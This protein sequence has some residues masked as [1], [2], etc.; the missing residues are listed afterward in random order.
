[1]SACSR[2]GHKVIPLD[3]FN[4]NE[5]ITS[6]S[7]EQMLLNLARLRYREVPMFLAVSSVLTQ[8]S[9]VGTLGAGVSFGKPVAGAADEIINT[10][11]RL[12]YAERPTITY[13]P[14]VGQELSQQLFTPI[15][16]A[17]L[18]SLAQSGWPTEQLLM[19]SLKRLN[20]V[21]NLPFSTIPS[22]EHLEKLLKFNR[23]VKLIAELSRRGSMEMQSDNTW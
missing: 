19:M 20:H 21:E 16:G 5:A 13:S 14:L 4:Y 15:P 6:S 17:L 1:M 2:F 11:A 12:R 8:Y 22:K 3:S 10:N 9:Y 7:N 23:V 18:F